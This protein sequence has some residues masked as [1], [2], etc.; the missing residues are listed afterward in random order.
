MRP[1]PKFRERFR[2]RMGQIFVWLAWKSFPLTGR[3][4][5]PSSNCKHIYMS[6]DLKW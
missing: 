4:C 1:V 2:L 5:L 3:G 6:Q